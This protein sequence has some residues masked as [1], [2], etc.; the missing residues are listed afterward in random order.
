[1]AIDHRTELRNIRTFLSLI[2][3]LRDEMDWPIQSDDFDELPPELAA[4]FSGKE[5]DVK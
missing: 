5:G 2:K 3:Y 4:A 1:M